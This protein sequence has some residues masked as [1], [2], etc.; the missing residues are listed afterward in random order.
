[1]GILLWCDSVQVGK[2]AASVRIQNVGGSRSYTS[3]CQWTTGVPAQPH[4]PPLVSTCYIILSYAK[5]NRSCLHHLDYIPQPSQQTVQRSV[6]EQVLLLLLLTKHVLAVYDLSCVRFCPRQS[7]H[8]K[9]SG[10]GVTMPLQCDTTT[11]A[12][13]CHFS[14]ITLLQ[15]DATS[16]WQCHFSVTTSLHCHATSARQCHFSVITSLQFDATSAW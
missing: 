2:A 7:G 9:T 8:A 13:Q 15:F 1:M 12:W 4:I 10:F 14:V 16:G 6:A 3:A 11:S 5:I